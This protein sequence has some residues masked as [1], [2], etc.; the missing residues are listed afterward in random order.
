M[1]SALGRQTD[2]ETVDGKVPLVLV[3]G[4]IVG[5]VGRVGSVGKVGIKVGLTVGTAAPFRR[6]VNSK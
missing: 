3:I 5:M 1:V 4:P 6:P 2:T